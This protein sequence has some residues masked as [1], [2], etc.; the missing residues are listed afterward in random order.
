MILLQLCVYNWMIPFF[1]AQLRFCHR[2]TGIL[3]SLLLKYLSKRKIVGQ[4]VDL[5]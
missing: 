3:C 4:G 1:A 2:D 5:K